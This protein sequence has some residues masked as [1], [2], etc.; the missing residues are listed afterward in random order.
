MPI[1]SNSLSRFLCCFFGKFQIFFEL[2]GE[3]YFVLHASSAA[4]R[5]SML[6]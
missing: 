6:V 5:A 3:F 4:L 2:G 1:T